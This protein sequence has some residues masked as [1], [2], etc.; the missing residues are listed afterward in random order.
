MWTK[1]EELQIITILQGILL[2]FVLPWIKILNER[3]TY[4]TCLI[5]VSYLQNYQI[6]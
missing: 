1:G 2:S 5:L 4:I 6:Q 3:T